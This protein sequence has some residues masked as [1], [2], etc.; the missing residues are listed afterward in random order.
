M[1]ELPEVETVVRSLAP[2]IEGRQI[3]GLW[4]S[5]LPLRLAR[6]VD[7]RRLRALCVGQRVQAVGRRGKYILLQLGGG[8]GVSVHLGMS[9]RLRLQRAAEARAAHTHVV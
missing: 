3:A 1:P 5:G 8:A 9:G 2:L 7:M 6:P 4:G